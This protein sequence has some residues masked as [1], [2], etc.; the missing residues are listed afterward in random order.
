MVGTVGDDT[1]GCC[2]KT[3][4]EKQKGFTQ[5]GESASVI[6]LTTNFVVVISKLLEP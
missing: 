5:I 6:Q 4:V 2:Q 3:V 1:V